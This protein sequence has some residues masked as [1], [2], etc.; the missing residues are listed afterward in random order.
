[1]IQ[2]WSRIPR[3]IRYIFTQTLYLFGF[4]VA[5]RLIFYFF[6][7]TTTIQ[8][9]GAIA[10]A[11]HLGLKFDMRLALIC[12]APIALLALLTRDRL[13][14]PGWL[15]R[16]HFAYLFILYAFL[17]LFYVTDLGHY[18]YLGIRIEP[19]VTRFL[20]HGERGTNAR[21]LWESY[22]VIKGAIGLVLLMA[23]VI[24]SYRSIF[25]HFANQ[26][27]VPVRPKGLAAWVVA[28]VLLFGAGIYG[29]VAYF[30]LRWSQAMFTRDN[31]ITS[32][33][34]NP[35]LYFVSNFSV[36]DDTYDIELTRKYYAPVA[37]YLGVDKPDASALNYARFVK[38][39]SLAGRP[40]VIIVM[41]ESGGAAMTSMFNNPMKATPNL[42]KL[43]DEGLFFDHFYV[44]AMSTARTVFGVTTGLPDICKFK[45]A[46]RHPGIVDQRVVMDQFM[47][48]EKYYLLGGNT[49]W[50]N[51]RAVFTNNVDSIQIFEEGYFKAPKADVWGVSD[52]DLITESDEIFR[53]AHQAGKPFVA[54]LQTA[55]NHEPYTTTSGKGD[56]KKVTGKEVD[57][58]AFKSAGWLSIDQ[59]NAMRYLDYNVGYLMELAAKSGYLDNTIFVFFGD[60]S[61]RLNPFKHMPLPEYEMGTFV[62]HVPCI[63]W[64]PKMAKPQ[65][66]SR[67][68]SLLDVYPTVAKM[69]GVDFTN[70]TMGVDMLDTTFA[71][72]RYAFV[73]YNRGENYYGLMGKK[74]FCEIGMDSGKMRLYD[75]EGDPMKDVS[76]AQPQ[77]A[78]ELEKL[79]RGFYES[80]RYLM[81]NNKKPK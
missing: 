37:E 43:A 46:S 32:L 19:S 3:Y 26:E 66:I 64:A 2:L 12:M 33:A 61:A 4:L 62:D 17:T 29:N 56:F 30:P 80:S 9:S 7:F 51:I 20:A 45:T 48:Y 71:G 34:L 11:W 54:F 79:T 72:E 6:F 10:K 59:F 74:Y 77:I 49:N 15:R 41:L 75:L 76:A 60:H 63:I 21:M 5:W 8:D 55:D 23:F 68:S 73:V 53:K 38:G 36:K 35:V 25:R 28:L 57:M 42:Q 78:G 52:F 70:Y 16:L 27:G 1:M 65:R 44:P 47:G 69:A 40:N 24:W 81:F 22:P 39:D 58:K 18:S 13:F 14:G 67:M 31:G 50:A